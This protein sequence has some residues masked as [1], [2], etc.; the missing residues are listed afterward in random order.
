M[1]YDMS[2]QKT[3]L[4]QALLEAIKAGDEGHW[5]TIA[6]VAQAAIGTWGRLPSRQGV[7]LSLER[8]TSRGLLERR[9]VDIGSRG[10]TRH[11]WR[12]S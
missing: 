2:V 12:L 11:Y 4:E 1:L 3:E 5:W 10:A 7:Q 6:E 8:L 9:Q